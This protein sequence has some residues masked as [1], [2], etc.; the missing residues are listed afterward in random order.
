M[1]IQDAIV[2]T[3]QE[4]GQP[5]QI[6]VNYTPRRG[7]KNPV[8]VKWNQQ[9]IMGSPFYVDVLD[10]ETLAMEGEENPPGNYPWFDGLLKFFSK[11]FQRCMAIIMGCYS[12]WPRS[13]KLIR[14]MH[15][16]NVQ[17]PVNGRIIW[18]DTKEIWFTQF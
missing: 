10:L 1:L 6:R 7:G 16:L 4:P 15:K 14:F 13:M 8:E 11:I 3:G 9:H 12:N 17:F 5:G 18:W 2:T